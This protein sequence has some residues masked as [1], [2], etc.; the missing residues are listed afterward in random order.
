MIRELEEVRDELLAGLVP[1]GIEV[2]SL[3]DAEGF[4]LAESPRSLVSLP[5]FD[6]SAMDGY[7]IR[8][9]DVRTVPASL[10]LIGNAAAGGWFEGTV[11]PGQAVRI[12]TGAPLPPGADAV[13]MQEDTGLDPGDPGRV[14]IRDG[15]KPWENIR[16]RGEDI[17]ANAALRPAGSRLD[18]ASLAL[19][20]ASGVATVAVHRRPRVHVLV[21]GNELARIGDPLRPGQIY[22]SNALMLASLVR[23]AGGVP[24]SPAP[25]PD[26]LPRVRAALREAIDDS[27]LVLTAGGASVGDY[28]LV[29]QALVD[30]GGAVDD[31]RI[32]LKPGKPFIR[33][34][35]EGRPVLGVPGNPVSAFVTTVLL[36]LPALR[37]LQGAGDVL[38]STTPGIL[39]EPLSNPESRRH[40][41][42]VI[43][44]PDGR[45]RPSGPQASH[46]LAS[47]AAAN[48][49]LDLPPRSQLMEGSPVQVIRW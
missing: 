46:R 20:A 17:G 44:A 8:A 4:Y 5:P 24:Q 1:T 25:V 11:G 47:L 42:R 2:L 38:P 36:V 19:L 31:W 39:G 43:S 9:A 6:N 48:G 7:A 28:D 32:A 10:T 33:G 12:F 37:R 14:V 18:A 29:R 35:L 13:V 3:A 27:D 15:V 49:L 34:R 26:D 41:I 22:E 23:S 45:V 30:L 21:T 16:F 40:F